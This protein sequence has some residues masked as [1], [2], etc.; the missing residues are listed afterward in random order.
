MSSCR[1]SINLDCKSISREYK[2]AELTEHDVIII[3]KPYYVH[4]T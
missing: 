1:T 3:N 4:Y 2:I